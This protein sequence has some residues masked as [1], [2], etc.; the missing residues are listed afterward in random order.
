MLAVSG[1][2]LELEKMLTVSGLELGL[3]NIIIG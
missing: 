1:L 2:Q 3:E